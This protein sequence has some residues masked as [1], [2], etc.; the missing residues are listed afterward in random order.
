MPNILSQLA[1][2]P[3]INTPDG[4]LNVVPPVG[5]EAQTPENPVTPPAEQK[6]EEDTYTPFIEGTEPKATEEPEEATPSD[7]EDVSL[8]RKEALSTAKKVIAPT[9]RSVDAITAE[10]EAN[11]YLTRPESQPLL[12]YADAIR[13][14][15]KDPRT[16]NLPMDAK[17]AIALGPKKLMQLGAEMER[18]ASAAANQTPTGGSSNRQQPA[19][20]GLK[21]AWDLTDA[22]FNK[23]V[24]SARG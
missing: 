18:K 20:A 24:Q 22:D 2:A 3:V 9:K 6:P 1:P 13:A 14:V 12:P 17:V 11:V 4:T 16:S 8:I 19:V 15:A 10:M 5:T 21:N 7:D 23:A